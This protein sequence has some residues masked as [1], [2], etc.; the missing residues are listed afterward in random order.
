MIVQQGKIS[1]T[2]F[3]VIDSVARMFAY[4]MIVAPYLLQAQRNKQ[5]ENT[6]EENND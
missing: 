1:Q 2:N 5:I 4:I 3:V 6:A